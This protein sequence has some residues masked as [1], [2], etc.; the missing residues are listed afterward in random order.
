MS[1]AFYGLDGSVNSVDWFADFEWTDLGELARRDVV[2]LQCHLG[3]EIVVFAERGAARSAWTSPGSRSSRPGVS[4]R[5]R[6]LTWSTSS[7]IVP[8]RLRRSVGGRS[9]ALL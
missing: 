7:P 9:T 6:A 5:S 8:M 3:T 2:H 1:S 4:R